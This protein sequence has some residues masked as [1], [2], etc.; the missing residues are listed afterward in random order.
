MIHSVQYNLDPRYGLMHRPGW[1]PPEEDSV[2]ILNH[3]RS[4]FISFQDR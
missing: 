4:Q 1:A 3:D 2:K